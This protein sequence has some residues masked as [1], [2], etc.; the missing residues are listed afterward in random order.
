MKNLK[1]HQGPSEEYER[2]LKTTQ[3]K[4]KESKKAMKESEKLR[5]KISESYEKSKK[6]IKEAKKLEKEA[7]KILKEA[8][9]RLEQTKNIQ[10][11]VTRLALAITFEHQA[12]VHKKRATDATRL[13]W[14]LTGVITSIAV[15]GGL[16]F[17]GVWDLP[18]NGD[19]SWHLYP[20]FG[21]S[22]AVLG[23]LLWQQSKIRSEEYRLYAEYIHKSA[24]AN[25]Y[26]G[27]KDEIGDDQELRNKLGEN[28][29]EG[30]KR[31]PSE[32]LDQTSRQRFSVKGLA[33][34]TKALGEIKKYLNSN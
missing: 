13:M 9:T 29:I 34:L 26:I 24:L 33:K 10:G 30:I 6:F 2:P 17:L 3:E 23:Y 22:T 31:N 18:K 11:A 12:N 25:A 19:P 1:D 27:Y 21:T 7:E 20:F 15:L 14:L 8:E 5:A 32:V 4:N 16:L 28:L